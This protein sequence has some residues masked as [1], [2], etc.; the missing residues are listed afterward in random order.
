M[1]GFCCGTL[2]SHCGGY[3]LLQSTGPWALAVVAHGPYNAQP[4]VAEVLG[5]SCSEACGIFP[6]QESNPCPLHQ[7]VDSYSL[8]HQASPGVFFLYVDVN[9]AFM[10]CRQLYPRRMARNVI[11]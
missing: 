10:K 2:A 4:P 6:E 11:L 8:Y 3:S 7:Q 1:R 9:T 5:F